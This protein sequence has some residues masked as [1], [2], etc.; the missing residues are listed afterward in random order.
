MGVTVAGT[1]SAFD[2]IPFYA[3]M[4]YRR[5]TKSGAKVGNYFMLYNIFD[6]LRKRG[7]VDFST[8]PRKKWKNRSDICEDNG[9]RPCLYFVYKTGKR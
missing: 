2:R 4:K 5:I 1:A 6:E 3:D 9:Y 8:H 7:S